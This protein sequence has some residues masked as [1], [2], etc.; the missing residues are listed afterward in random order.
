MADKLLN[1]RGADGE[2]VSRR[3]KT[4]GGGDVAYVTTEDGGDATQ[5][6]KADAAWSGTGAGSVVAILKA[7]WAALTG[8]QPAGE[9]HIGQVGSHAVVQAVA[10]VVSATTY[11]T[12]KCI[13]PLMTFANF[14]RV[15]G[16]TGLIQMA[17]IMSKSL[18]TFSC[19]LVI[20][21]TMPTAGTLTDNGTFD[22]AAADWD[23]VLGVVHI[24]DWTA[25]GA[26]RSFAQAT[27]LAMAYKVA[28]GQTDIYGQLVARASATLAVGDI[29]V[30]LKGL[31]D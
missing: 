2:A 14:G 7:L 25:L 28:S 30:A 26:T 8:A 20:F 22:V 10:P 9:N 21:H 24:S 5:G 18:Q 11:V 29:K 31:L 12:G 27:A 6:A 15:A 1:I 4:I 3:F 16:G 17:S 13:G 19:D 23:K